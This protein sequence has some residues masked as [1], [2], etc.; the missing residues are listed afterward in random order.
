MYMAHQIACAAAGSGHDLR[1]IGIPK[2]IDN[3]LGGTDH[4]PGYG[5]TA[6]FFACALRDIG[7]DIRALRGRVTVVEVMGR[8]AGWLTAATVF[9]RSCPEDPPHLIYLPE[10]TLSRTQFLSDVELVFRKHGTAVIAVCEGQKD[11]RGLPM[12]DLGT[13]DGFDRQLSGN[14]AH[15]LA[16]LVIDELKLNARSE[17]P[18]LLGRSSMAFVSETDRAEA[19]L[20][21]RAA[22]RAAMEGHS[23]SMISLVREPGTAYRV[24]TGLHPLEEVG[25]VERLFPMEWITPDGAGIEAPFLEYAAPLLGPM[26]YHPRLTV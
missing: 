25:F 3:D 9:A 6:W 22:V 1:V 16:R 21:G 5:S 12:G 14:L 4:S 13:P 7:E 19:Y 2:T 10:R 17:K 23:D 8:N 18:G 26:E 15:T 20:C 11:E 24:R